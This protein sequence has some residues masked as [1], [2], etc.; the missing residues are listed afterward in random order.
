MLH[1]DERFLTMVSAAMVLPET[2][3]DYFDQSLSRMNPKNIGYEFYVYGMFPLVLNKYIAVWAKNDFYSAVGVT[4]RIV[5][6]AFDILAL[7][8]V[9]KLAQLLERHRGFHRNIKYAAA[10]LYAG[11]VLSIQLSHFFTVDTFLNT[12]TL[13][14]MYFALRFYFQRKWYDVLCS[15][16]MFALAVASKV[17]AVYAAPLVAVYLTLAWLYTKKKHDGKETYAGMK[18]EL[19]GML[20]QLQKK[21]TYTQRVPMIVLTGICFGIVS[22]LFLRVANPFYFQDPSFFNPTL[23]ATFLRNIEQLK[24]FNDPNGYFP[25]SIQWMN[26]TPVLFSLKNMVIFGL[27][28]P[29]TAFFIAGVVVILRR[30]E[31]RTLELLLLLGWMTAYFLY[32]SVQFVK[33]M[34][35]FILLYPFIALIAGIGMWHIMQQRGKVVNAGII[36]VLL[37]WPLMFM[38]VYMQPHSRIQATRWIYQNISPNELILTEHWDDPLPL[39]LLESS[40]MYF[41]E[42]L[43][44]F[45][46]DTPD[47]FA[48]MQTQLDNGS[49]YILTSNRAWGSIPKVPE[50]YPEMAQFYKDLFAGEKGYTIIKE[51]TVYPSLEWLGIP[52]TLPDQWSDESFTVYD[53]PKVIIMKNTSK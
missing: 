18:K 48:K 21:E 26:T 20:K 6:A 41:G 10:F 2:P 13:G 32:Q 50:K 9:F 17:S 47:K 42:Q 7:L 23:D 27:G 34:R 44:V 43:E 51:F 53:H 38:N 25:P 8:F 11:S 19:A 29:L 12:M 46:P 3:E 36:V 15:A 35:Y 39:I 33:V 24:S 37:L 16:A 31:Y 1:P 30:K 40:M 14:S 5:S 28:V 52:L 22:Y 4:G 45:Y 49:Y